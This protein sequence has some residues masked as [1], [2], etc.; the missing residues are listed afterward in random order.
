MVIQRGV[1][2]SEMNRYVV[3]VWQIEREMSCCLDLRSRTPQRG[4]SADS[5]AAADCS[6][7]QQ[8]CGALGS[9]PTV[10]AGARVL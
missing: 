8:H 5:A 10:Q 9:V 7:S 1:Q 6:D 2:E 4:S 3:V